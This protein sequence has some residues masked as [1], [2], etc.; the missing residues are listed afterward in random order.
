MTGS[1]AAVVKDGMR[2]L[3]RHWMQAVS[4]FTGLFLCAPAVSAQQANSAWP[5][6]AQ[7][8]RQ[9]KT[10]S[11]GV[12]ANTTVVP[13]STA[14]TKSHSGLGEVTLV[15]YLT[16]DGQRIDQGLVWRAFQ[17]QAG[18]PTARPKIV[19]TWREASPSVR[20]APGEY[21]VNVAF[22]RAHM[23]RRISVEAGAPAQARFVLNVG[24]LRL[25]ALVGAGEAAPERTV[26]YDIYSGDIDQ[27][28]SR[29]KVMGGLRPGLVVR[30]NAGIYHVVS[31]YG[32]VNA[33]VKADV[34]VEAGK[35]TEATFNHAGARVTFK[36][37]VRAGGEAQADA[38]WSVFDAQGELVKESVGALP[39]HILGPGSYAVTAKHSGR[40]FRR[41]FSV[42]AS[43]AMQVEIVMQ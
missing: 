33:T 30:L 27:L 13:R 21:I 32:D 28:G 16:D 9:S 36:L 2:R 35:L 6:A 34:T 37:V 19:G 40:S 31:T 43:E 10:I 18:A 5:A 38:Q 8:D 20:L 12:P 23:T 17:E 22:G 1:R 11:P 14:D 29:A 3:R 4:V 15:A 25:A 26:S 7:T 24:G 41:E 39:T 42:R